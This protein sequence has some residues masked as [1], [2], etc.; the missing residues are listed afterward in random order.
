MT[1][2]MNSNVIKYLCSTPSR[3][4]LEVLSAL[5]Y[6]MF[7]VVL[8]EYVQSVIMGILWV[9]ARIVLLWSNASVPPAEDK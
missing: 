6:M 5:A 4:L 7:N 3:Y 8:N 2:Q 1:S 9:F